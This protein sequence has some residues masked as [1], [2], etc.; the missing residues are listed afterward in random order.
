MGGKLGKHR[1][2]YIA[3]QCHPQF[4]LRCMPFPVRPARPEV[5]YFDCVF[6]E[7]RDRLNSKN[8]LIIPQ[9]CSFRKNTIRVCLKNENNWNNGLQDDLWASEDACCSECDHECSL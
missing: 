9:I 3:P 1:L 2:P 4:K 8:H 6:Y 7:V 5:L